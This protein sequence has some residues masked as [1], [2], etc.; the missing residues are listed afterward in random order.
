M[1]VIHIRAYPQL[2]NREDDE[3]ET[4][5]LVITDQTA[6]RRQS[7]AS[8]AAAAARAAET[9]AAAPLTEQEAAQRQQDKLQ[10][11][12][13]QV[14]R[15]STINRDLREANDDLTRTNLDLRQSNEEYLVTTEELQAASEEVETLNE[16]LQASNEE[17]ETLNEELQATVEELNTS[18]DDLEARSQELQRLAAHLEAQRRTSETERARLAAILVNMGDA[19]L[20]VDAD[21]APVQTNNAYKRMFGDEDSALAP[22]DEWGQPL[23]LEKT[24]QRRTAHGESFNMEFSM[25][26]SHGSR[27]WFEANGQPLVIGDVRE[28]GVVVIRDITDRSLRRLQ[29]EFLAQAAHEL[30]TPLTSAQAALQALA[31]RRDHAT[32]QTIERNI[33]IALNQVRRLGALVSDLVDVARLQNSKLHLQVSAVDLAQIAR[34]TIE[35]MQL[36][37]AQRIEL[38]V[39]DEPLM[40]Y[41]D[42]LRLEQVLDNLLTNAAKYAPKAERIEVTARRNDDNAEVAV[43]DEGP[44]IADSEASRLFSRFFQATRPDNSAQAGLGLGLFITRELM[45]AQGGEVYVTSSPGIGSTFTIRLPLLT[46]EAQ[47]RQTDIAPADGH[48]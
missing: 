3:I 40:V 39:I 45:V 25:P 41:G 47:N 12:E 34:K 4:V 18:N 38:T 10:R 29:N 11:L 5:S 33:T 15:L 14:Q 28:G 46:E 27:R 21:G 22:E 31:Q 35:A 19:V 7:A 42:P 23:S 36:S 26:D 6:E 48:D 44:G 8:V 17:L 16:E 9:E 30:R 43:R 2:L 20:V 32:P 13:E 1:R 37:V 24:P